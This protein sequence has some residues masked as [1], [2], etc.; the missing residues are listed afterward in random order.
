MQQSQVPQNM[1]TQPYQYPVVVGVPVQEPVTY[2]A[3]DM[4]AATGGQAGHNPSPNVD[5]EKQQQQVPQPNAYPP[6]A[7][8]PQ[9]QPQMVQQQRVVHQG[10][11][12]TVPTIVA[13]NP[14]LALGRYSQGINCPICGQSVVTRV[15]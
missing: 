6:A 14:P 2:N 4:P 15:R 9:Q 1:S 12:N 13:L 3:T 8:A 11:G 5:Y 10:G 7:P